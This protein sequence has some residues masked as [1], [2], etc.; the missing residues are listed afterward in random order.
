MLYHGF[1]DLSVTIPM[2]SPSRL[3]WGAGWSQQPIVAGPRYEDISPRTNVGMA[4]DLLT[5][6]GPDGSG[7][8]GGQ[9]P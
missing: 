5:R 6:W 1:Y 4:E 2:P 7:E 9:N 8:H 3:F